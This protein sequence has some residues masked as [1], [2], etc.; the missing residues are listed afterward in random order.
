[1]SHSNPLHPSLV[2]RDI[3]TNTVTLWRAIDA[4]IDVP[5]AVRL[6]APA[7]LAV[8]RKGLQ[9]H[10]KTLETGE[11]VFL[12]MLLQGH[13]IANVAGALESTE[14]LADPMTLARWLSEWWEDGFLVTSQ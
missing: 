13:S 4:D 11:A 3:T 1:M 14:H 8:W 10:F 6:P 12:R 2:L 9:P 7:T 5:E